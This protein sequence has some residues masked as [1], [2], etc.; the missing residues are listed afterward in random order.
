MFYDLSFSLSLWKFI[1]LDYSLS[2]ELSVH[3]KYTKTEK[4]TFTSKAAFPLR[5][6]ICLPVLHSFLKIHLLIYYFLFLVLS[7][8]NVHCAA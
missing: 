3:M 8:H 4:T 1:L 7:F 2:F 6:N 5:E